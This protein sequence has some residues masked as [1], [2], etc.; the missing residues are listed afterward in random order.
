MRIMRSLLITVALFV[1]A[2][3]IL[4]QQSWT[5]SRTIHVGGEGAWDYPHR[6]CT[7]ASIVCSPGH[8]YDG[9]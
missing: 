7:V 1:A 9:D 2:F 5:V 8:A 6:R 4:A 3:P